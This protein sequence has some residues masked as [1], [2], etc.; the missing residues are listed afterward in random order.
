MIN[1]ICYYKKRVIRIIIVRDKIFE[2]NMI[3]DNDDNDEI[4]V[5]NDNKMKDESD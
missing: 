1:K 4:N 2:G 5:E 3:E